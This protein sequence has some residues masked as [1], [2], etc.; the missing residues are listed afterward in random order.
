MSGD[1]QKNDTKKDAI[2]PNENPG[3]LSASTMLGELPFSFHNLS[4]EQQDHIRTSPRIPAA[5][6][7]DVT[8]I[9]FGPGSKV[10]K[11]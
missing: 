2:F 1:N 10:A 3:S 6:P 8:I 4:Q 7:A 5:A 9:G 11:K